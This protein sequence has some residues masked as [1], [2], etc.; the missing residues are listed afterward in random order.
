MTSVH[1][2]KS[3]LQVTPFQLYLNGQPVFRQSAKIKSPT[4][5]RTNNLTLKTAKT[6]PNQPTNKQTKKWEEGQ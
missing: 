3:G 6:K 5:K 4:T 2:D 1:K